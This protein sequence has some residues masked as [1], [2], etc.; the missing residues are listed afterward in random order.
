MSNNEQYLNHIRYIKYH[1][2]GNGFPPPPVAYARYSASFTSKYIY[3]KVMGHIMADYGTT[4]PVKAPAAALK[5]VFKALESQIDTARI[6]PDEEG[7]SI[8]GLALSKASMVNVTMPAKA[9]S[10]YDVWPVFAM[11]VGVMLGLLSKASGDVTLDISKGYMSAGSGHMVRKGPILPDFEQYPRMPK[12]EMTA[13]VSL[14]A[15]NFR[16]ILSTVSDKEAKHRSLR[17]DMTEDSLVLTT[18][19]PDN[20]A[21]GAEYT[22][23]KAETVLMEGTARATYGMLIMQEIF[24]AIPKGTDIDIQY[25]D[26]YLMNISYT[27]EGAYILFAIAP[28]IEDQE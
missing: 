9:F 22:V 10:E 8:Y 16:D 25:A 1:R 5:A 17:F 13:E 21:D 14:G 23:P 11:D 28:W 18:E 20:P 6:V 27:V 12:A 26:E 19:D 15:D 7:W 3:I 24:G 4:N 2:P